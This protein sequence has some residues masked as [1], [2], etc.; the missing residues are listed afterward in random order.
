[1]VMPHD[2]SFFWK[3]LWVLSVILR[4]LCCR[5]R[6]EGREHVPRTGAFVLASNHNPGPDYVIIGHACPRQVFYMAKSEI[7]AVHPLLTRFLHQVGTFP[8][9]RG[10]R[11]LAAFDAAHE[12][13]GE[14]RVVGMFPEG[15]RSRDGRLRRGKSGAVRLAMHADVP[16][17]PVAIVNSAAVTRGF[18][19]LP[20]PRVLVRF[21]PPIIVPGDPHDSRLAAQHTETV[22]R[23]IAALLPEELRGA[24]AETPVESDGIGEPGATEILETE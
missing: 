19:R 17:V 7:F 5:A 11:D 21:G 18:Y 20:K 24:Y 16:V 15:T 4:P 10:R 14:G 2:A 9:E 22:M 1:M 8:V 12:L 3:C 23:A 13:L 6:I